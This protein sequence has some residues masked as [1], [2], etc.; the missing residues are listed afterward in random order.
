MGSP[1]RPLSLEAEA[2]LMSAWAATE[3]SLYEVVGTWVATTGPAAAKL[4]FDAC[5]Q[6]HAWRA[7]LWHERL[8]AWGIS[9]GPSLPT[10]GEAF[11]AL[12]ALGS[13]PARLG[14][15]CRAVLE[16]LMASY[17]SWR[18]SLSPASDGPIDRALALVLADMERDWRE[19]TALLAEMLEGPGSDRAVADAEKG[20]AAVELRLAGG[21]WL[22]APGAC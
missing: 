8:A 17:R 12:A 10:A 18:P 19:G 9:G 16:R 22:P 13:G 21:G 7:Q 11:S 6:H 3:A 2:R 15:Y 14:A 20:C 4:Y 5:S 1:V